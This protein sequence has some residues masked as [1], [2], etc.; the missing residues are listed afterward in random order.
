MTT[1]ILRRDLVPGTVF[2]YN[3]EKVLYYV[4]I[5]LGRTHAEMPD[6]YWSKVTPSTNPGM[7]S[8][9]VVLWTPEWA[10]LGEVTP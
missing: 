7:N 3:N 1:A 6:C 2:H 8:V 9:V 10:E 4:P 5:G